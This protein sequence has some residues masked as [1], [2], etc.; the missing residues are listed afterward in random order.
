MAVKTSIVKARKTYWFEK[1]FWAISSENYL[2][3]AGRDAQQNEAIVKRYMQPG[4]VYV[5]ADLHGASSVLVKN[6]EPSQEIP[7][8]TLEEA[9]TMAI[10][11]SH[12]WEAKIVTRAWWVRPE[13]VCGHGDSNVRRRF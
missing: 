11:Y 4:D 10:S 6:N 12:A 2:I 13:Q 9:A 7:P 8:R 3:I 5:H 1:F